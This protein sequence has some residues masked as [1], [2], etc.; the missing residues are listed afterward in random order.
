MD[1]LVVEYLACR[2]AASPS[3]EVREERVV[4]IDDRLC[5]SDPDILGVLCVGMGGNGLVGAGYK[6]YADADAL[7][8]VVW[9][10][11]R[12]LLVL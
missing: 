5:D 7:D 4:L 6:L 8:A 9:C 3:L 2:A 10:C 1:R 11:D 12:P